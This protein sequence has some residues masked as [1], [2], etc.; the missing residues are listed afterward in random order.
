MESMFYGCRSLTT[1]DLSNF[2]TSSIT[3]MDNMFLN[4]Q[5]LISLNIQNFDTSNVEHMN[6]IFYHCSSLISL[7]I[8]SFNTSNVVQ[9]QFC[10]DGVGNE[11]IL[12]VDSSKSESISNL[13]PANSNNCSDHCFSGN[14]V[15]LMK[16]KKVCIENCENDDTYKYEYINIC[17]DTCPRDTHPIIDKG[18]KFKII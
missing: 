14:N 18:E 6:R 4:C 9:P 2:R 5:Q 17:Y 12:F 11:I 3:N 13:I 10:F 7:N 16:D 8:N 15:K 1:L